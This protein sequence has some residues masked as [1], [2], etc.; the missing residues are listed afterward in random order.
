MI[1]FIITGLLF[2]FTNSYS[3]YTQQ[4]VNRQNGTANSFD[5]AG[6]M[7]L[8]EQSNAYVYSTITNTGSMTDISAVKYSSEG[9]LIWQYVYSSPGI[10]QLQDVYKD[11][12][13]NSYITGYT[14]DSG[15]IKL[16]T[17]KLN[18]QGSAVWTK[19]TSVVNHENLISHSITLDNY[20]NIFVLLDAKDINSGLTDFIIIKYNQSG[21]ILSQKIEVAGAGCSYNGIKIISDLQGNVFAGVNYL[22]SST[23]SDILILKFDNDLNDV[24]GSI[25]NWNASSDDG[26]VDMKLSFDNNIIVTSR[27]TDINNSADIL[28]FKMQNSNGWHIWRQIY[29][30]AG[31]NIDLPY[32]VTTDTQNN[33]LVTGYARNSNVIGSEDIITLKYDANGNLLWSKIYNDS[34][35]GIDQGY[36]VCTDA[37]NNVYVGGTADYGNV[38][39]GYITLKYDAEGNFLWKSTYRYITLSEDFIYKIAVNNSQDI[40]VS[41]ISFSNTTDY[42]VATIKYARQTGIYASYETVNDFKLYSNYP[43]PFNPYT[44][45]RFYNSERNLVKIQVFDLTGKEIALIE[46]K[47]LASGNYEYEFKPENLSGGVYLYK[48][49]YGENYKT[50]KMIFNK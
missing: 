27:V 23:I 31:N 7:F 41:G 1:K 44:K 8:D 42:D 5:I 37:Q 28:T 6:N 33:I 17:V 3:Q 49:F 36:S 26:M 10:D 32:S 20:G 40:F 12:L 11:T 29:N 19:I 46:N 21:N 9:N 18:P 48:V 24:Y 22:T 45:I 34:T 39:N 47:I 13:N 38:R 4:W 50:G 43:N 2:I 30:G 35:N 14:Q 15:Q 25:T 16:L